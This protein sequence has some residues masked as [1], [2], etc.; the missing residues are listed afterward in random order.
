MADEYADIGAELF[1]ALS[2]TRQ[3]L[4]TREKDLS[5]LEEHL[6][7]LTSSTEPAAK[8]A[9]KR[10]SKRKESHAKEARLLADAVEAME[11]AMEADEANEEHFS[12]MMSEKEAEVA[13]AH[14]DAGGKL[15][16]EKTKLA[17]KLEVARQDVEMFK[18]QTRD[19]VKDRDAAQ[20]EAKAQKA[21]ADKLTKKLAQVE[22]DLTLLKQ[23]VASNGTD[24][25]EAKKTLAA[26]QKKVAQAVKLLQEA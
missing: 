10:L 5:D 24:Q 9:V 2:K 1:K 20:K 17:R 4:S 21:E 16:E 18:V 7:K 15:A 23:K 11:R 12:A 22:K 3:V 8:S 14:E 26:Y 19:A 6:E 25:A 13:R